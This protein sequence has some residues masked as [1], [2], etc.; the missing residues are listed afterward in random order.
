MTEFFNIIAQF[1]TNI[2]IHPVFGSFMLGILTSLILFKKKKNQAVTYDVNQA[3][4]ISAS[5]STNHFNAPK[6]NFGNTTNFASQ[7]TN[8]NNPHPSGKLNIDSQ[9][10]DQIVNLIRESKII[11]AI[12]V[13]REASGLGLKEA[14]DVIERIA[15]VTKRDS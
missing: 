10:T 14:K 8:F 5:S 7:T 3:K 9:V 1:F 2:G 12:R 13:Y 6:T 15:S 11:E 4:N